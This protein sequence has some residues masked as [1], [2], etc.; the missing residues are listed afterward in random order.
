MVQIKVVKAKKLKTFVYQKKNTLT[1]DV[2]LVSILIRGCVIKKL[3]SFV[4]PR[5]SC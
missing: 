5:L 3:Y 1:V 2:M 4:S